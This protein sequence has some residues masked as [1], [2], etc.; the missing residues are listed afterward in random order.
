VEGCNGVVEDYFGDGFKANFGVPIPRESPDEIAKDACDAVESALAMDAALTDLNRGYL[1]RGL[2]RCSIRVGIHSDTAVAGSIGSADHLKYSVV[3]DVVVTAARLGST[4]TIDHDFERS[5]SRIVI[6]E[7]T[8]ALVG[9]RFETQPVGA[10]ALKG[11]EEAVEAH[12]VLRAQN[13]GVK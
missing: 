5:P 12:R 6:S 13:P 8:L 2:P 9:D 7:R 3:G 11:K 4:T 10:V 1:E